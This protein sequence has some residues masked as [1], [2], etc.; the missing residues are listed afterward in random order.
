MNGMAMENTT[1]G[2]MSMDHHSNNMT[3]GHGDHH[4]TNQHPTAHANYFHFSAHATIL[5]A[6]WTTATW[7]GK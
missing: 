5:F 2:H 1:M 6:G 3:M 7:G 4:S